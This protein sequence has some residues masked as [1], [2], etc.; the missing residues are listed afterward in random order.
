MAIWPGCAMAGNGTFAF[1]SAR[2]GNNEI[3]V[4]SSDGSGVP[5]L[6]N[7]PVSDQSPAWSPDGKKLAFV[8]FPHGSKEI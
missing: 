1:L 7:H 8:S 4:M 6:T 2:D 5:N 3:Y